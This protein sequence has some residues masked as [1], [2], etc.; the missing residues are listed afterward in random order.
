MHRMSMLCFL[1]RLPLLDEQPYE[2]VYSAQWPYRHADP[3][4]CPVLRERQS[5]A[6][7]L[8]LVRGDAP[9]QTR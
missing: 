5:D 9:G 4:D 1:C 8:R 7:G 3:A 2:R 6:G